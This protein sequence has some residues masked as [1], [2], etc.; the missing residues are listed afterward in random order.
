M[1]VTK[2]KVEGEVEKP[3]KEK[4]EKKPVVKK[5]VKLVVRVMNTDLNGEKSLKNALL[6]I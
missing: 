6:G 5:E 2:V 4:V 1:G 3:K